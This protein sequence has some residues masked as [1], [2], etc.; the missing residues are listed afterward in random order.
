M[1]VSELKKDSTNI[2]TYKELYLQ[3]IYNFS[4]DASKSQAGVGAS[5]IWDNAQLIFK[6]PNISSIFNT[7]S[8]AILKSI[9]LVID[10]NIQKV[11]IFAD[12]L[13]AIN[14][15]INAHNTN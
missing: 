5:V 2:K 11:T 6:L 12:S 1:N 14:N 15:I 3:V 4:P 13:S 7:E 9:Q 8:F 10:S